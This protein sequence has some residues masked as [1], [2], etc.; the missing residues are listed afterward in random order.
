MRPET[1]NLIIKR[2]DDMLHAV[3][4]EVHGSV[5]YSQQAVHQPDTA[6]VRKGCWWRGGFLDVGYGMLVQKVVDGF[7]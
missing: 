1:R 2:R 6:G 4:G 7:D 3:H 5:E